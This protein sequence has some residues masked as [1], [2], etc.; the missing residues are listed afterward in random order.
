MVTTKD[1]SKELEELQVVLDKLDQMIK[2]DIEKINTAAANS[3]D[4]TVA[5]DHATDEINTVNIAKNK[6]KKNIVRGIVIA[7]GGIVGVL[8]FVVN[9]FLGV[10]TFTAG[11]GVGVWVAHK[12]F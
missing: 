7:G 12:Y 9:P 1:I 4:A 11:I 10:G 2:K 8:G 3:D 5:V 6:P